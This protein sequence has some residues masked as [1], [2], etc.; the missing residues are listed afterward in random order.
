MWDFIIFVLFLTFIIISYKWNLA[1]TWKERQT[2]S[3]EPIRADVYVRNFCNG[4]VWFEEYLLIFCVLSLWGR[5]FFMLRYN[6]YF[7]RL[8]GI[9]TRLLPDVV[10]FFFFYII[11]IFFFSMIA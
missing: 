8:T 6:E 9:V 10:V 11:E 3:I 4:T 5:T 1:T 7:G 2:V